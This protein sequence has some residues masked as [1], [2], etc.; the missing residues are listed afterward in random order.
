MKTMQQL[1]SLLL[2]VGD[3]VKDMPNS[4]FLLIGILKEGELLNKEYDA[5]RM[6]AEL[7]CAAT[8]NK[9]ELCLCAARLYSAESFLCKLVIESQRNKDISKADTLGPFSYLLSRH[10]HYS[11]DTGEQVLYRGMMLTDD[12][13]EEYYQ[14]VGYWM[15]WPSYISTS[16]DRL[17]SEQFG[18]ALFILYT[19]NESG[20][21][22]SDISHISHYPNEQEVLLDSF[23]I[24][25]VI[26]IE[27][28][29]A[30]G[31]YI[32]YMAAAV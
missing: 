20:K 14:A 24:Y 26:K 5:Q 6:A 4:F 16:K 10:L 18:N 19:M 25:S 31:K 27:R 23:G 11:K 21:N 32:I 22:R 30:S 29:S 17:V 13:I 28:E 8:E 12:M 15:V 9:E 3:V 1:L 2:K 7:R